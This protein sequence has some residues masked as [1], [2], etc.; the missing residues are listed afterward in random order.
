M[1]FLYEN[2]NNPGLLWNML[3]NRNIEVKYTYKDSE[4]GTHT[5][6]DLKA[7]AQLRDLK[8]KIND[9]L[10]S[11]LW[12]DK[13]RADKL[14]NLFNDT[15]NANVE[16]QFSNKVTINGQSPLITLRDHQAKLV[17]R[18]A[19]SPYNVLA[20]HGVGA[21]KTFGAIASLMKMKQLGMIAKPVIVV[22]KNKI[23]DWQGD[24]YKLFPGANVLVADSNTFLE[25]KRKEFVNKIATT[26][27]D[28]VIISYEQF[29]M[30]P[31]TP[32]YQLEYNK[33][34]LAKI[35]ESI[36]DEGGTLKNGKYS[37]RNGSKTTR[38]LQQLIDKIE[39]EI[40]ALENF[41][42]DEN[43]IFFEETGID[44]I[45]VDEAQNYKNLM[46]FSN[47]SGV[48]DMGN[49]TGSQRAK[50]MKTK[51][52]YVRNMQQGKGVLFLTATP[53]MNSPV[54]AYTQLRYLADEELEKK[55]IRTLDD[56]IS[57]FG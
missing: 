54:E 34:E 7:E 55:G 48:A 23:Q 15:F 11:W 39:A 2:Q 21:G 38:Q 51:C 26:D 32:E 57:L 28:A 12:K 10:N 25:K 30:I 27:C 45:C 42:K 41:K 18:V 6:H 19:F 8:R 33:R 36:E 16:A 37:F 56:F 13:D 17:N 52:D 50:D 46:Y 44:Y 24:F 1:P 20:Q 3:N 53:I 49:P 22:P 35:K 14:E 4:G 47:L 29:K 43:N 31:M 5:E 9:E 40:N